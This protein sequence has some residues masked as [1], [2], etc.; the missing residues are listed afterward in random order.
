VLLRISFGRA[1]GRDSS[2]LIAY[3]PAE[4]SFALPGVIQLVTEQDHGAVVSFVV[5]VARREPFRIFVLTHPS[6]VVIDVRTPDR[7]ARIRDFFVNSRSPAE[8]PATVP[9]DRTV[10][11]PAS[12]FSALLRLFAGPTPAEL[13]RGL[14]FVASGATGFSRLTV[15]AGVARVWLTGGCGNGGS[16]VT[17][18]AEIVPTLLQFRSVR[19]VKIFDPAGQTERPAGDMN[20]IPVCLTPAPLLLASWLRGPVIGLVI[21]TGLGVLVGLVLSIL[22]VVTGLILRP[23]LIAPATYRA[24]RIKI[25]PV[26]TGQFAPDTAWP[27]YPVRQLRADLARIE[28]DR[29]S[30]YRKLWNWPFRPLIWILLLPVSAAAVVCLVVAGLTTLALAAL[31]AMVTWICAALAGTGFA[32]IVFLLR[33]I[34]KSWHAVMHTEASCPHCY[35]VTLQPAYRCPGCSELHRDVRPGRLGLCMRRCECGAVLPTMVLR[36]AW[37]LEAVCQRCEEPLRVGSA[38]LRDV[39]IP[40]FG[41]TSA[42]KTR[43]LYAALDSLVSTTRRAGIELSF[44]DANSQSEAE[45]ALDLIRSGHET[46]KT[47]VILPTALTCRLGTGAKSTLLHLF[48]AAGE[49]FRTPQM[50]DSLGFLDHGHGLVYVLDPL[51][52]SSVRNRMAGHNVVAS[53]MANAASGDPEVVYG[54]VVSRLRDSGVEARNQRLAIVISKAD[55]LSAGGLDLAADTDAIASWLTDAGVH[56][57]VLSAPR[58]FAEVRYFAVASLAADQPSQPYDPGAPLRWLLRSRGVRLPADPA[59]ASPL[60]VPASRASLEPGGEVS[61]EQGETAKAP[62]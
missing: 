43:F 37:R 25:K 58:E 47:T 32:A 52:I 46:A 50:H 17:V 19:W 16:A 15:Q 20:S 14:R 44:P 53:G 26:E 12:A 29:R 35:H 51:S 59:G 30:R 38:A 33:C 39:R 8:P 24:E 5:A 1:T 7:T 41:D 49:Y 4:R 31:F 27:F 9:A 22:S 54:E 55:L 62:Q 28:A 36:A 10:I 3:G 42:G 23:D 2:G 61:I 60:R 48:D 34:E 13:A 11:R 40:I 6:R 18:T 21:A 45:L 56:N 57:I